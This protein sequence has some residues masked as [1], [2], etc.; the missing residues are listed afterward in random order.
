[1]VVQA[2]AR[3]YPGRDTQVAYKGKASYRLRRRQP[4]DVAISPWR[5][6]S[7]IQP[8]NAQFAPWLAMPVKVQVGDIVEAHQGADDSDAMKWNMLL[9]PL[10]REKCL[11]PSGPAAQIE[12]KLRQNN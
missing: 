6:W 2:H 12:R 11:P 3:A 10:R 7:H 8:E 1:M 4:P 5:E 9:Q